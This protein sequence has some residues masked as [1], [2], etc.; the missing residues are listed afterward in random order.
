MREKHQGV[1]HDHIS[2]IGMACQHHLAADGLLSGSYS[3]FLTIFIKDQF[4]CFACRAVGPEHQSNHATFQALFAQAITQVVGE[5]ADCL[6]S[7]VGISGVLKTHTCIL[8]EWRRIGYNQAGIFSTTEVINPASQ[9]AQAPPESRFIQQRDLGKGRDAKIFKMGDGFSYGYGVHLFAASLNVGWARGSGVVLLKLRLI[10]ICGDSGG[11]H[12]KQ[13]GKWQGLD[14]RCLAP[15]RYIEHSLAAIFAA[16]QGREFS[17]GFAIGDADKRNQAQFAKFRA[18][19]F[20]QLNRRSKVQ[21]AA[22]Q[23][24]IGVGK[25]D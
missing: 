1:L 4:T 23:I 21:L 13:H 8:A 3:N 20:T 2:F 15:G 19:T 9:P 18:E 16:H 25:R 14:K 10:C 12:L 24:D 22:T 6:A 11:P 7:V 17:N 5:P